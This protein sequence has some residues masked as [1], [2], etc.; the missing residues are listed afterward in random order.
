M[1]LYGPGKDVIRP[2]GESDAHFLMK[3]EALRKL[4]KRGYSLLC[5]EVSPNNWYD[6]IC[7]AVGVDPRN[8]RVAIVEA[9]VSHQ[10]FMRDAHADKK[11]KAA[12]EGYEARIAAWKK[13]GCRSK[14]PVRPRKHSMKMVNQKCLTGVTEAFI[15]TPPGL[16]KKS[17]IPAG[18]GY[19]HPKRIQ[20]TA[21]VREIEERFVVDCM[22]S[23]LNRMNS[24]Y[25]YDL[26]GMRWNTKGNIEIGLLGE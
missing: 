12:M 22:K 6:G 18:W 13:G 7:D 25:K 19:M 23:V 24:V 10:D 15:I 26:L 9:K 20:V 5:L 16:L 11:A 4:R 2:G 14:H 1:K 17:E 8:K 3:I 21:P